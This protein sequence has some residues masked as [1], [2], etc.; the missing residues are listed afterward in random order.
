[1]I[2]IFGV[3]FNMV[4]ALSIFGGFCIGIAIDRKRN[5]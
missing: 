4:A 3:D 1:M 5:P 2:E